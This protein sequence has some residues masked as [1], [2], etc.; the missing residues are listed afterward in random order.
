MDNVTVV[1]VFLFLKAKTL[2]IA[3]LLQKC[4]N[5]FAPIP[6]K[7]IQFYHQSFLYVHFAQHKLFI[8]I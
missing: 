2:E 5:I 4:K 3:E 1:L 7:K 6:K 8:F